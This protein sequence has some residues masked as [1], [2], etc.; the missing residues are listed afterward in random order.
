MIFSIESHPRQS[1]MHKE[2]Y[3]HK[4]HT[5]MTSKG[6]KLKEKSFKRKANGPFIAQNTPL[7]VKFF[8]M[9]IL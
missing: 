6:M 4:K 5:L 1:K 2:K 7:M 3:M 9:K 8:G